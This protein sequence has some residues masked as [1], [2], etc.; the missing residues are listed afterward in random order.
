MGVWECV[1]IETLSHASKSRLGGRRRVGVVCVLNQLLAGAGA[2]KKFLTA[3][4]DYRYASSDI[5]MNRAADF[6][7]SDGELVFDGLF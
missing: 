6:F 3:A 7:K 4:G 2:G 1:G 5:E